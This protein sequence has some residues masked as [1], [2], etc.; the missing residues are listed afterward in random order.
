LL[1][2]FDKLLAGFRGN[3]TASCFLLVCFFMCYKN[4]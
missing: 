3:V 1:V 4:F 2:S